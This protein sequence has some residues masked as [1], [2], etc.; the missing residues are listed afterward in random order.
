VY[1][2]T[3]INR[4]YR[5]YSL[6]VFICWPN[7]S[8]AKFTPTRMW[9]ICPRLKFGKKKNTHTPL[10][11]LDLL[12][13]SG[14]CME[15]TL[16]GPNLHLLG[17]LLHDTVIIARL[18]S[19]EWYSDIWI[20]I[21]RIMTVKHNKYILYFITAI[22]RD[23]RRRQTMENLKHLVIVNCNRREVESWES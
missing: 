10:R 2:V 4:L 15:P 1:L 21:F 23:N 3:A 7:Q 5:G 22:L 13:S 19:V 6:L 8:K 20:Y 17:G 16:L 11:K 12:P 18:Y 14:K 9:H